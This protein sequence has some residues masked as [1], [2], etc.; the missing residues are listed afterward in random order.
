MSAQQN[1]AQLPEWCYDRLLSNNTIVIIRAGESGY[2]PVN[3]H[4]NPYPSNNVDDIEAFINSSNKERGVDY[5]TRLAMAHGS[6]WGWEMP[7]A[8]PKFWQDHYS[9]HPELVSKIK[10]EVV[11]A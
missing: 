1:I 3:V 11:Y 5:F 4:P 6:M 7:A 8:T 9:K 2:Y 10:Y